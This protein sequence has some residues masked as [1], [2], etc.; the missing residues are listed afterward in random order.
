MACT[1]CMLASLVLLMAAAKEKEK[2]ALTI[3]TGACS[4]HITKLKQSILLR[5]LW[6]QYMIIVS[7]FFFVKVFVCDFKR[8]YRVWDFVK[9]S[10]N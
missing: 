3:K 4:G 6:S 9:K 5:C 10:K 7:L 1:A 2:K 8:H